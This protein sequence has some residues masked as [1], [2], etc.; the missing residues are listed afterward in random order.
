MVTENQIQEEM[1]LL[2][3][4]YKKV[5]RTG[6][7]YTCNPPVVDTDIDFVCF[8][9]HADYFEGIERHGYDFT[10]HDYGNL[11]N[12]DDMFFTYRKGVFNVIETPDLKFFKKF[13]IATAFCK[14][15]NIQGKMW[16]VTIFKNIFN[17]LEERWKTPKEIQWV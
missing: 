5:I 16:R 15:H 14:R 3:S 6:S 9:Q 2:K 13:R 12:N 7:S 10:G 11:N 8:Y 1:K 4:V 17:L